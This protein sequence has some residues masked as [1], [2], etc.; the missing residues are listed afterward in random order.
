M[1]EII[2]EVLVLYIFRYP[3]AIILSIFSKTTYKYYLEKD[4]YLI[5]SIGLIFVVIIISF[6]LYIIK[7]F[8]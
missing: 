3:G 4:G 5:G 6:I 7:L 2:I 8:R 1:I